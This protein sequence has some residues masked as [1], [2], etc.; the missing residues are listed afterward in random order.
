MATKQNELT[1]FTFKDTG[2]TVKI[3]KVSPLLIMQLNKDFPEPEAPLQEV[4][5]GDGD[6]KLE[7][8]P[9]HP[10]Y[11]KSLNQYRY[12]F[13]QKMREMMIDRGVVLDLN[14][15]E[16]AEIQELRDYWQEKY[17]KELAGNDKYIYLS[18]LCIGTDGDMDDLVNAIS[19]R[20]QPTN[21]AVEAA[22]KSFPG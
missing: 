15:D 2:K 14:A 9:A 19:R 6:I 1:P 12:D 16:K 11:E 10:D 20:S 7:P 5:Y 21:G 3:K 17:Q 22:K 18:Y 8:N 13:E 4:D